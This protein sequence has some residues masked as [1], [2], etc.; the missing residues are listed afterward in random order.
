MKKIIITALLGFSIAAC[1]QPGASDTASAQTS[2][3][4]DNYSVPFT[5]SDEFKTA[6][7]KTGTASGTALSGEYTITSEGNQYSS[8]CTADFV[9]ATDFFIDKTLSTDEIEKILKNGSTPTSYP[10]TVTQDGGKIIFKNSSDDNTDMS[11]SINSDGAYQIVV[12][13]FLSKDIYYFSVYEGKIK[14][15]TLSGTR[16]GFIKINQPS[17]TMS[18]SCNMTDNW[19]GTLK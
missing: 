9:K 10:L 13:S 12:G 3:N 15:N 7:A 5:N 16:K 11:G 18:G 14:Q 4:V 2:E 1:Q 17:S 8:D 6:Q 19:T